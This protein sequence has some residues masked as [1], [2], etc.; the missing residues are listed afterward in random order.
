MVPT[1]TDIVKIIV[2]RL[3]KKVNRETNQNLRE[4]EK[5]EQ[6]LREIR[7]IRGERVWGKETGVSTDRSGRPFWIKLH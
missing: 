7:R 5:K 2:H 6:G 1:W 3:S 4:R